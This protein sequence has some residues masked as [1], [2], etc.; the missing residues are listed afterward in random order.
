MTPDDPNAGVYAALLTLTMAA[1]EKGSE[2]AT[3]RPQAVRTRSTSFRCRK[4]P[5]RK[6]THHA[7]QSFGR[8]VGHDI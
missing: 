2:K 8:S 7:G 3:A 6:P 5:A 4:D 1:M